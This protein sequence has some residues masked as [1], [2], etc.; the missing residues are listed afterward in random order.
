M[1][2]A[3]VE[4]ALW[5]LAGVLVGACGEEPTAA[6]AGLRNPERDSQGLS[7]I[8]QALICSEGDT[9]PPELSIT[10][11]EIFY[12]C[13]GADNGNAW[14]APEVTAADACEGP[15]PLYGYN[16]GDDDGDGVPGMVDP[17]DFGPGPTTEA[18]GLYY[19]QYLAWDTSYNIQGAIL[20]V[21]VQDTLKPVLTLNGEA[22]VQTQCFS[23]TD[24]PSIPGDSPAVDP[25]PYTDQGATADD[26]CYSDLTPQVLTFGEVNKQIPG[27]YS[28]EYQVR[29]G[30]YNWADPITRTVEVVDTLSP[31]L[32]QRPAIRLWPG[33]NQMRRVQLNEC[34]LAWDLCEGPMDIASRAYDLSVTSNKPERDADD[35]VIID[36][37]T[38]EVRARH[39][40][41][42][43]SRIYTARFKVADSSG[44][45]QE[46]TCT[47]YVPQNPNDPAP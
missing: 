4:R 15:V 12:E 5:V 39:N 46:A 20:S 28:L 1:K 26:Q 38:F 35:I 41:H 19:V 14:Q 45:V 30:A 10:D 11:Q 40:T 22:F 44:N 43:A 21:F 34:T 7:S 27:V 33:N 13:T 17:D 6:N 47:L 37:S 2:A 8:H 32:I 9:E 23:P 42:G 16:T 29:D 24:D 18:E 3:N 31:M 36:N 25:D